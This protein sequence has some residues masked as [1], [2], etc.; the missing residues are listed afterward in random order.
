MIIVEGPDGAGKTTLV[1]MLLAEYPALK[2]GQ[3]GT[4][5]RDKLWTVT[6]GD[7][8]RALAEAVHNK[9]IYIW[10]RLFYSEFV[11]SPV[12]DR[13]VAFT[14]MQSMYIRRLINDLGI[15]VVLC[16]PSLETCVENSRSE[17]QMRGVDGNE[18]V[19]YEGYKK[20]Y[21]ANYFPWHLVHYDYT[22]KRDEADVKRLVKDYLEQKE[23]IRW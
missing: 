21:E 6:V 11:Y 20:L 23:T 12:Q 2:I 10:D 22:R 13:P 3:R 5:D 1:N 7:T 17:H 9:Q 19:I 4:H 18:H 14:D 16:M 8:F 15:P